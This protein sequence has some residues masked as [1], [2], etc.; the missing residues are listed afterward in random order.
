MTNR[1]PRSA[2]H[3]SLAAACFLA[4]AALAADSPTPPPPLE[5]AHAHNDYEHAHP[6]LDALAHGFTSVEADIH[7]DN[8][9][10]LVAHDRWQVRPERTLEAL[11]LS[12]LRDRA[13]AHAGRVFPQGPTFWLLIDF[14][15]DGA[16]TWRALAPLL[17]RYR[18]ML[19]RF[20]SD[21]TETNAVTIV[22]SGNA[23]R[24]L[25]VATA[26]RLAALDG[27]AADLETNPSRHLV[28][29]ISESWSGQ[30]RWRGAGPPPDTD[31]EKLR[32]LVLRAHAQGRRVRFWGGPDIE[33]RWRMEFDAGV[34]WINTD[35]L[36]EL[37]AYLRSRR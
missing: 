34:D 4:L 33:A 27:R 25:I 23:P 15:S 35:R 13:R 32:A 10:L 18:E 36:P 16:A 5:R 11:Y 21:R 8:G 2:N 1:R 24:S 19:T 14:K 20:A 28:P 12:P 30:F 31:L 9:N 26:E 3:R 7:L 22:L 29:W 17:E 6:L 37:A